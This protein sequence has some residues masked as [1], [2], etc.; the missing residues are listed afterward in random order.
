DVPQVTELA[1]ELKK[2]GLDIPDGVLSIQEL[3]DALLRLYP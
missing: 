3:V 2:E 1:Y